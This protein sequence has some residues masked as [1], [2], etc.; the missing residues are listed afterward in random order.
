[1]GPLI[2]HAQH[3]LVERIS[4]NGGKPGGQP[5]LSAALAANNGLPIA[6]VDY[7]HLQLRVMVD[8]TTAGAEPAAV[9]DPHRNTAYSRTSC[10][11]CHIYTVFQKKTP[12][13]VIGYKLRNSC[14]ILIIFDNKIPYIT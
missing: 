1:V 9:T 14:L 13:H 6:A 7:V 10:S 3:K 11:S 2:A 12:I 5:H 4:E 8:G